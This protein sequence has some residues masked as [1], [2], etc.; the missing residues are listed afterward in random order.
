V[1]IEDSGN[2]TSK[3]L[4]QEVE[5]LPPAFGMIHIAAPAIGLV[6]QDYPAEFSLVGWQRD[7]KKAPKMSITVKVLDESGKPTLAEPI[8]SKIPD[9][10]PP[11]QNWEKQEL[12]RMMSPIFLNRAGRFTVVWEAK[13][14]L[15]KA[16]PVKFSY[17]MTV[18]DAAGK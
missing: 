13:D 2:K 12:V 4:V 16:P 3:Q 15:S 5:V 1:T 8:I 17:T 10:L 6:G 7:S 11:N 14:E 9:D 18:I